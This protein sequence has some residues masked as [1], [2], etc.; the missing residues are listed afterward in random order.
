MSRPDD[1]KCNGKHNDNP[2]D[3]HSQPHLKMANCDGGRLMTGLPLPQ[4]E[5]GQE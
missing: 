3:R 1:G 2:E 5:V 4:S